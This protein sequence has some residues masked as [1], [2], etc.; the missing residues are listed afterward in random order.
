MAPKPVLVQNRN[1]SKNSTFIKKLDRCL[2]INNNLQKQIEE[3]SDKNKELSRTRN[4]LLL[5]KL[6]LQN[7]NNAIKNVN[8]Q[9]TA[10]KNNLH[11]KLS[12][13][14]QT[15]QECIPSLVTMSQCIPSMLKNVHEMSKFEVKDFNKEMKEKQTK[16]VRPMVHG[17]TIS[18]PT[19]SLKQFDM[20]PIIESPSCSS[21]P[22]PERPQRSS[23][24]S[25]PHCKL[26]MEPYVR[27]KDVAAMLKNSKAVE[28]PKRR[29]NGSL[30]EGPSWLNTQENQIQCSNN[31]TNATIY[32]NNSPKLMTPNEVQ[33]DVPIIVSPS[34]SSMDNTFNETEV[35]HSGLISPIDSSTMRNITFRKRG[36]RS[37][38]TSIASDIN[39][40]TSSVRSSRSAKKKINYKENSLRDKLRR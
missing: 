34:S 17:M 29:L 9:L 11:R 25:S 8:T 28:S 30:G 33:A 2:V 3:L 5:E 15:I 22:T 10:K 19:V 39:D 26:N 38:E 23:Y 31:N 12:V 35:R 1:K 24:R 37:S 40:S 20:L 14:E 27:L 36:K 13:L 7:E 21:E 18:Q 16:T 32:V 6:A 4:S